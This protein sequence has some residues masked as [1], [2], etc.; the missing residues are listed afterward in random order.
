MDNHHSPNGSQPQ[1][2]AAA[3]RIAAIIAD[4][5]ADHAPTLPDDLTPEEAELVQTA[6][7]LRGTLAH[8]PAP[9]P[10][11][12]RTLQARLEG[13]LLPPA[14]Q[15][16]P[17]APTPIKRRGTSRRAL[18][19]SGLTAAAG[20]AAGV[21]GGALVGHEQQ[22]TTPPWTGPIVGNGGV[23]LAVAQV[24][25]MAPGTALRFATPQIVGHLLRYQ[26]GS[27]AA[28][29]AACTHM[30]CLLNWN[31]G[32]Q[33]FDCPCH[34]GRFDAHGN[35]ITNRA[36]YRPLPMIQTR[37]NGDAVE[38]FVPTPTTPATTVTPAP[39]NG[40]YGP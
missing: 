1:D 13:E 2:E 16:M 33:T 29:S 31:L 23:W 38:V 34:N 8:D 15:A 20:I 19:R 36:L 17:S 30:G 5:Q 40:G 14:A 37:L 24:S 3:E 21:I 11:F 9:T 18:V 35:A 4:L 28:F 6:A 22:N 27:F 32:Q 10:E 12:A 39:T 26:D 25:Q 7:L